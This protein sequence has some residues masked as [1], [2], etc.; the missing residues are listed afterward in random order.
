[1]S[2][3][4]VSEEFGIRLSFNESNLKINFITRSMASDASLIILSKDSLGINILYSVIKFPDHPAIEPQ[5]QAIRLN[6]TWRTNIITS[7]K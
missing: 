3:L 2:S 6:R 5:N 1:M 7:G 4:D